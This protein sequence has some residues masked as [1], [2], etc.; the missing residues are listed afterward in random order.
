[1][2]YGV[3]FVRLLFFDFVVFVAPRPF[4]WGKWGG[5]G[6][7]VSQSCAPLFVVSNDALFIPFFDLFSRDKKFIFILP[8]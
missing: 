6:L 5:I 8:G 7:C 1:M 4:V 2:C 3:L